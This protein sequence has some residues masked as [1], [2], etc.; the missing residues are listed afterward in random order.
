MKWFATVSHPI[1][2]MLISSSYTNIFICKTSC[3]ERKLKNDM[4]KKIIKKPKNS[5]KNQNN[6]I[7]KEKLKE[8]NARGFLYIYKHTA[9]KYAKC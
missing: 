2:C 6:R 9:I 1:D 5:D 7:V 4:K 8:L 3:S